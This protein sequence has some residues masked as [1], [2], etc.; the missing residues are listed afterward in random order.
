MSSWKK[1]T[2]QD[3]LDAANEHFG[4]PNKKIKYRLELLDK[5]KI[6]L[7][8]D[9]IQADHEVIEQKQLPPIQT[10]DNGK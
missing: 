9:A 3:K 6:S 1:P 8:E 5:V 7:Y 2:E 4:L 10:P